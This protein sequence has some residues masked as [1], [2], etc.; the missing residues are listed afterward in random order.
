[1]LII[2]AID[3]RDGKCVRLVKGRLEEETV[4]SDNPAEMARLWE[5]TGAPMLH[6]VDLDG[7]FAGE[8]KNLSVIGR[9][10]ESVTIPLQ[11]GGGIRTLEAMENILAMG[12]N[13]LVLGTAAVQDPELLGQAVAKFGDKIAVGVDNKEGKVAVEG[14]KS[15]SSQGVL[16]FARS[17][18]QIGVTRVIYTDTSR[19]GTLVGPN[20]EGIREFLQTVPGIRIIISG[21]IAS[22]DNLKVLVEMSRSYPNIEGAILGKSLY[23][24]A[25]KLEEALEIGGVEVA[26]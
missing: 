8:S 15:Y 17:L 5:E 2:P 24:N 16:D 25:I 9:I 26:G 22:I 14:W 23:S 7:A 12:V 18:E 3:I 1:M 11:L 21:G 19:D 6:L 20:I 13:R 10:R 4:Y